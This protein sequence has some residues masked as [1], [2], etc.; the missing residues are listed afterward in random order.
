MLFRAAHTLKPPGLPREHLPVKS[1]CHIARLLPPGYREACLR[2][3][4]RARMTNSA[5]RIATG[6][7]FGSD[8][9]PT[10]PTCSS[11]PKPCFHPSPFDRPMP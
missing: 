10:L 2:L 11:S 7:G 3:A 6:F 8:P 1:K 4:K 5:G 9:S